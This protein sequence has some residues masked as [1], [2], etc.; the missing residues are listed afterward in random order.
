MNEQCLNTYY[1]S[2]GIHYRCLLPKGHLG[3]HQCSVGDDTIVC[4]VNSEPFPLPVLIDGQ[5][6]TL[7]LEGSD[8]LMNWKEVLT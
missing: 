8:D 1:V 2:Q 7:K 4:W 6:I 3:N 5:K